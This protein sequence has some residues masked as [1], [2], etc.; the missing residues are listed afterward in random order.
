MSQIPKLLIVAGVILVVIGLI[1]QVGGRFFNLGRLPGDI[2][3]EKE[4]FKFYFPVVTSIVI[5]VV[6]SLILYLIRLFR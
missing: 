5:S 6:L 1:W 2:V 3:I 4:N